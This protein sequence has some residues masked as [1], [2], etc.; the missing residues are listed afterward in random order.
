MVI[1]FF[2]RRTSILFRPLFPLLPFIWI[3]PQAIGA[4]TLSGIPDRINTRAN[5]FAP[6][7]TAQGDTLVFSSKR[8]GARFP[9]IYIA[10]RRNGQWEN[11][12]KLDPLN[13]S[14]ADESPFITPDGG[15]IFFA[16]DRDGSLES[17]P[18]ARGQIRVS[19]DLYY[20]VKRD[21]RWSAPERLPGEVNTVQHEKAPALDAKTHTLYYVQWP[22][23]RFRSSRIM[24]AEYREGRFTTPRPLPSSINSGCM[25]TAPRPAPDGSGLYFSSR[26][27]GGYGNWDIYFT[28]R[29]NGKFSPPINQGE[30]YNSAAGD[31]FLSPVSGGFAFASDR[32]GGRGQYDIY[33]R[34][35]P[36][37][38]GR[39]LFRVVNAETERPLRPAVEISTAIA[40]GDGTSMKSAIIKQGDEEGRF[41]V[42][43]NRSVRTITVDVRHPGY[44][45]YHKKIG[46][47]G[48]IAGETIIRLIP[49][50]KDGGFVLQSLHFDFDSARLRYM[51]NEYL[52]SLVNYLKRNPRLRFSIIG[53]TDLHGSHEYN[54]RLSLERARA[55][56]DYLIKR[57]LRGGRFQI[58]GAGKRQP[59][60]QR[61]GSPFDEQNRRTE[62]KPQGNGK[63]PPRSTSG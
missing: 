18:N 5:E 55:V 44:L 6:S 27:P 7:L 42:H 20:S 30:P 37:G 33:F 45:P 36:V 8:N 21:G 25:E 39:L 29:E 38:E 35:T 40:R 28:R 62:F 17:P 32:P 61:I 48:E 46:K 34:K 43:F 63:P 47:I 14:Y 60:H 1:N 51:D 16:S 56:R 22:F 13:S 9:D 58:R 24:Q 59:R 12:R 49:L 10:Q 41:V 57:G 26:R 31:L 2:F 23:G 52:D 19:Y 4:E 3:C 54:D 50:R 11:P 15:M 53:H